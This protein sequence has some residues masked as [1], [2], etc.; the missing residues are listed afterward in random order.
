LLSGARDPLQPLAGFHSAAAAT[1]EPTRFEHI[2]SVQELETRLITAKGLVILDFYADW[3]VSC[4]EMEKFTFAAPDVRSRLAGMT[5]LQADV[6]ANSDDHTALLKRFHL[7]GPPAIVR[8]IHAATSWQRSRS[9]VSC[10]QKNSSV[11]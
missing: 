6:T 4:I 1:T 8:L 7:F 9:Y 2:A 5:L 3:C 10:R 11:C